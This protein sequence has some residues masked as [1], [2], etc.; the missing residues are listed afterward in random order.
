MKIAG[1]TSKSKG[2][3]SK[4]LHQGLKAKKAL[5]FQAFEKNHAG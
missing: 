1:L 4:G 3:P 5:A 2:I